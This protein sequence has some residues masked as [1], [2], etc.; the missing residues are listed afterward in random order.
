MGSTW[1]D[2]QAGHTVTCS[3]RG[4]GTYSLSAT[5]AGNS[6]NFQITA[7]SVSAGGDNTATVSVFDTAMAL[8]L[9]DQACKV[10]IDGDF[11][12]EKGA[13]WASVRCDH[14]I[15]NDDLHLWCGLN[16]VIVFKSCGT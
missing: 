9:Y 2:G 1:I 15:S 3:V 11:K 12:V 14:L 16:G 7:P 10:E 4:S 8:N 13:I 5:I 6:S